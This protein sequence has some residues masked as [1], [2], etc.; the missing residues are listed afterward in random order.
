MQK[1]GFEDLSEK[2]K[3]L[4]KAAEEV[5]ELAYNPYSGFFVG[6]ALRT[7][8]GEIITGTN[9]ENAAYGSTICAERAALVR[10]NAMGFKKHE[11]IAVIGRGTGFDC[12]EPVAPCGCCRQML[13]EAAQV[14]GKDLEILMSNTKKNVVI[15]SS[16]KE[17]LPLAF[18]PKDL[19]G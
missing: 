8:G 9:V 12:E 5:M 18:G 10:A 13:Y 3:E 4:L 15:K 6:A 16:I 2:E 11:A 7:L 1:V 14:S 19:E 17:L